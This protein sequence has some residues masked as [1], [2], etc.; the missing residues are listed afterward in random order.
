MIG[1]REDSDPDI[2]RVRTESVA[3]TVANGI[4]DLGQ[5]FV[6]LLGGAADEAGT[7]DHAVPID[8][9]ERRVGGQ[10]LQQVVLS[11]QLFDSGRRGLAVPPNPL[12]HLLAIAAGGD[13]RHQDVL[14]CHERQFFPEV[15]GDHLGIDHQAARD[16]AVEDQ[17]G[18]DGEK[19][20]RDDQPPIGAVVQG[21][22]QPLGGRRVG[23]A[24]SAG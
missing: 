6:H 8:G 2:F 12:V 18:V 17:D 22:F 1:C 14:G 16:I 10:T 13:D 20:L 7:V 9:R 23:G 21:P 19:R 15:L 3:I 24:R 11:S 5:E 4:D